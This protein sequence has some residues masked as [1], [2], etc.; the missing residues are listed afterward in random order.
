MVFARGTL[1]GHENQTI[2][3]LY[4][5]ENMAILK[6][7]IKGLEGTYHKDQEEILDVVEA[8]RN[9]NLKI[10]DVKV[11]IARLNDLMQVNSGYNYK[12]IV[13]SPSTPKLGEVVD[14]EG[15]ALEDNIRSCALPANP[16][17]KRDVIMASCG[18]HY[19][20]WCI[21]M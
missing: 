15:S 3:Y 19:H 17:S 13:F 4:F 10:D 1:I 7:Q 12:P 6:L 2:C 14:S 16:F 5:K 18:Y 11:S 20:L 8:K 21:F 9:V